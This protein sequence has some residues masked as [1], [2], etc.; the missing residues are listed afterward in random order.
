MKTG[1]NEFVWR[2]PE[3]TWEDWWHDEGKGRIDDKRNSEEE[4]LVELLGKRWQKW[5]FGFVRRGFKKL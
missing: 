1:K 4:D 3:Y 2:P 5:S